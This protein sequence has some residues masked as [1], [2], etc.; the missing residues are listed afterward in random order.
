MRIV[1]KK[2][3]PLPFWKMIL[4]PFIAIGLAFLISS[5]IIIIS[6]VNFI[7]AWKYIILG[8]LGSKFSIIE[9]LV[10][11]TPLCLTG[12]A[13][14]IAFKIKFWNIGAEGQLYIGAMTAAWLGIL[15]IFNNKYLHIIT[16][17][18]LSF[19]SGGITAL[20]PAFLKIKYKV[21]EVVTTLM[22]NFIIIYI[23][24]A[25]LDTVWRDIASGWPHSPEILQTA[26]YP[27]L[28]KGYRLHIGIYIAIICAFLLY[29]VFNKTKFGYYIKAIGYNIKAS[30]FSG[31]NVM[32]TFVLSAFISGGLAGLAGASE[33]CG[34]QFYLVEGISPG[35]GYYGV[36]IAML[37]NLNPIAVIFTS[38]FFSFIFTGAQM[39][40]RYTGIPVYIVDIL[41]GLTLI[42]M[43]IAL[44][45]TRYKLVFQKR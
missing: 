14:T 18:I 40:S 3:P 10:K 11:M 7:T 20:I 30:E 5:L 34:V 26:R 29:F 17:I 19:I 8:G 9:T 36:A 28:I 6:K 27:L 45:F 37:A 15:P 41:Q 33:V 38:F 4:L 12:L 1:L 31:I 39:M 24:K 2:R 16:I 44:L 32:K 35:Y 23:M 25:I 21:D 43:M 13:I 42:T 22:L